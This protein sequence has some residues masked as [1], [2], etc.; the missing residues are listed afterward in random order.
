MRAAVASA[1]GARVRAGRCRF[2]QSPSTSGVTGASLDRVIRGSGSFQGMAGRVIRI[3]TAPVKA[4]GLVHPEAVEL[5]P[6]GVAATAASG[7]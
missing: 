2:M 4:L 7:S 3:S 1:S 5:G 6:Q